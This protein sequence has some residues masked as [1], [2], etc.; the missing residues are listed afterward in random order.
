MFST[1]KILFEGI[2][3]TFLLVREVILFLV[4]FM[5]LSFCLASASCFVKMLE[6]III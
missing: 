1:I 3:N 4:L 6:F 5:K 2:Y